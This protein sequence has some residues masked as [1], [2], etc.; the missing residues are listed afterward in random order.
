MKS[1]LLIT[2]ENFDSNFP[3]FLFSFG[4]SFCTT[5]TIEVLTVYAQILL[6]ELT[7]DGLPPSYPSLAK[8][9]WRIL[10]VHL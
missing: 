8:M 9:C 3:S 4:K 5:L 7:C 6:D 2:K 10:Y 1:N